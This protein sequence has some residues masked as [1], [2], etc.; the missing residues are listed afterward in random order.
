MA[1][2]PMKWDWSRAIFDHVHLRVKDLEASKRFYSTVLEPL[3]IPVMLDNGE[4][5]QWANLAVSADGPPSERVHLAFMAA[6]REQVE[7]FHRT[8]TEAGYR[9]NGAPGERDYGPPQVGYYAAYLIDPDGNNVE[10]VYRDLS[11]VS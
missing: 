11:R 3:G 7:A 1:M 4:I 5:V 2:D 8:G 9:D 6:S 10:A